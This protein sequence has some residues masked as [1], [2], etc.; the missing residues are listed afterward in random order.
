[1]GM[2]RRCMGNVERMEGQVQ[3]ALGW[4]QVGAR[5]WGLRLCRVG[6]RLAWQGGKPP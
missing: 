1:M 5:G 3:Q 2:V 4:L 6:L